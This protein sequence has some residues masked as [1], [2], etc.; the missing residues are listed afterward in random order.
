[1]ER[2]IKPPTKDLDGR[3]PPRLVVIG[4]YY[5]Q[6]PPG[7][8]RDVEVRFSR[9]L[10]SEDQPILGRRFTVGEEWQKLDFGW[11]KEPGLIV[12]ENLEGRFTQKIPFPEEEA[13][14]ALKVLEIGAPDHPVMLVPTNEIASLTPAGEVFVRCRSGSARYSLSVVPG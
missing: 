14:A 9:A 13:A 3:M 8:P 4:H 12:I 2:L 11:I 1:M 10:K 7:Q 6:N 5:H